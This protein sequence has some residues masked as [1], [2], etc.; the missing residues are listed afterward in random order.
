[1]V[2]V[3]CAWVVGVYVVAV[4]ITAGAGAI[5]CQN[6]PASPLGNQRAWDCGVMDA[7]G[8][9]APVDA[10]RIRT[11][12]LIYYLFACFAFGYAGTKETRAKS[13]ASLL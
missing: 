13:L 8:V 3:H 2:L 11:V 4:V 1:M 9:V 6:E 12:P 5:V 7:H 10:V